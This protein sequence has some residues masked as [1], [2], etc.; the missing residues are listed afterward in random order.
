[1]N[2]RALKYLVKLAEFQHFSKAAEACFVSQPTLS[3]QIRKLEDE[4][5]VQLVE[6]APRNVQLTQVGKEIVDRARHVLRDIEQIQATARRSKDP[7]KGTLRLG[8]FPTLAPYLLPHVVPGIRRRFPQLKL[9]LAEEKTNDIIRLLEDG[10]LDAGLL[11]LPLEDDSLDYATLFN[12]PFV[13]AIPGSHPLAGKQV[14]DLSDLVESELLLLEEGHC[15]RDQALEVCAMAGAHERVDFHATSMET[16][17]QMVAA[18]VGVTLM[19]VLSVRP[20]IAATANVELR[21]FREPAPNRT[22]ALV[23][24]RSSPLGP[25]MKKLATCLSDLPKGLLEA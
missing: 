6:R 17:R 11:A 10:N 5:G 21:P 19:P 1:M 15:L 9:Q 13:M 14:I 22:I 3:T 20:P 12:E 8:I 24:R 7:E 23:W 25:L 16:L 2:L 4:L 18:D